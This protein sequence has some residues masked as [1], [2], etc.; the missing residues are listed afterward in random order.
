MK[1]ELHEVRDELAQVRT[2][3][4]LARAGA[5]EAMEKVTMVEDQMNEMS[6]KLLTRIDVETIVAD[7][8]KGIPGK[9]S[10]VDS[11]NVEDT[12]KFTRTA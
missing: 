4:G 12:D 3:A 6:G 1:A 11:A 9:Q 2:Q 8:R 10:N 5:E 7:T